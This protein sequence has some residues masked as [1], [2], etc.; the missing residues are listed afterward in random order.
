MLCLLVARNDFSLS[1]DESWL[2]L[3][4]LAACIVHVQVRSLVSRRGSATY[5]IFIL[6]LVLHILLH[7]KT[8]AKNF[9]FVDLQLDTNSAG[10][11][12]A[13][14]DVPSVT[15]KVSEPSVVDRL[16]IKPFLRKLEKLLQFNQISGKKVNSVMSEVR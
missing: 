11:D 9:Y 15:E 14:S 10:I 5:Y 2:P 13:E 12:L 1:P 3:V 4:S 8:P 7:C 16:S 6:S